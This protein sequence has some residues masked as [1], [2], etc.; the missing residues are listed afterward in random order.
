MTKKGNFLAA[1]LFGVAGLIGG[2]LL[3]PKSGKQIRVKV[4]KVA[5]DLMKA[6]K[7]GT[8]E[9]KKRVEEV[10]GEA[11]TEV[12]AKY[13]DIKA[14]VAARVAKVKT[15]GEKIDKEKYEKIVEEVVLGF[16]KDLKSGKT[17]VNKMAG[18]LKRDWEKIKK[19]L[20]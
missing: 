8:V 10:F 6:V 3:A 14:A 20:V 4:A 16:K 9:T 11:N 5:A 1:S 12:T 17:G 15:T 18:Y 2:L 19:S 7:T 13:E